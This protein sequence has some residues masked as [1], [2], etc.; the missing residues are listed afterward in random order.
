MTVVRFSGDLQLEIIS[1][2]RTGRQKGR[3]QWVVRNQNCA[4][5]RKIIWVLTLYCLFFH[6][7]LFWGEQRVWNISRCL[8]SSLVWALQASTSEHLFDR[9]YHGG[10]VRRVRMLIAAAG[11][12]Y[13]EDERATHSFTAYEHRRPNP[14]T[15]LSS[16]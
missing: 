2:A 3:V 13:R 5:V 11:A 14:R 16:S 15:V 8:A 1:M 4:G 12:C 10:D 7:S 6:Y 9:A